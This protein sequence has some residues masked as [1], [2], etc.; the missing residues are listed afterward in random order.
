MVSFG[1]GHVRGSRALLR[2]VEAKATREIGVFA[3]ERG[4][5]RLQRLENIGVFLLSHG[6]SAGIRC[7]TSWTLHSRR[8]A[9]SLKADLCIM[10][11]DRAKPGSEGRLHSVPDLV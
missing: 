3:S 11:G 5:S 8:R 6:E 1:G 10:E 2:H 4:R 7:G 9:G